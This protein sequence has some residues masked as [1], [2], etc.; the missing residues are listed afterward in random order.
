MTAPMSRSSGLRPRKRFGQHFL[1]DPNI[2]R[3][4][5]DLAAVQ[6]QETVLEIGPGRG[7][8]TRPLCRAAKEVVAVEIDRD[9]GRHLTQELAD[10][11]N[12]RLHVGDA[13]AF[14]YA[15]LPA[16]TAI[17]ANLP[18]NISTPLL[19]TFLTHRAQIDRMVLMVQS[20]VARRLVAKPGTKDYGVLSVLVQ[21]W[22]EASLAFRVS[23][24]C[25]VPPP[26]VES[27]VVW[28]RPVPA[29]AVGDPGHFARVVKAAFAHRRKTLGNSLRDEGYDADRLTAALRR[30]GLDQGRRAETLAL[31]EFAALSDALA[32]ADSGL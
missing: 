30:A 20:E 22:C 26:E 21:A 3:K 11:A 31:R 10:C 18:Y 25:F 29:P 12:L 23:R 2:V 14:D 9:L 13:L 24:R 16:G 5:L 28:L 32:F 7:V 8:L 19:F 17:V 1:V 15:T 4:I 6:P 27:A